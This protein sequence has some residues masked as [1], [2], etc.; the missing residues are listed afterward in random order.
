MDKQL[1]VCPVRH[2]A[3]INANAPAIQTDEL[4]LTYQA[5]DSTL[6]LL[7]RQLLNLHLQTGDR[8]ICLSENSLKL[9][10]LQL[11]CIRLGI[12]FC[13]LNPR[14]SA[15]EIKQRLSILKSNFIWLADPKKHSHL[16]SLSIDFSIIQDQAVT[17]V[18][19]KIDAQ[20]VC[21]II[22]T[23][24]SSG[25]AKAVMHSYSNH[26][27]SAL[28][29]QSRILLQAKD[30]NLLSLPLFHISGFAA[31]IR[32]LIAGA[33]LIVSAKKLSVSLLKKQKI[34]HLSLVATQLYRLLTLSGFQAKDLSIKHLL[35][36][37]SVFSDRLL[38]QTEQRGFIYHLSYGL[39]EMSS[40]VATSTNSKKL[41][42]LPGLQVKIINNEICLRG[43]MRFAGY[44]NGHLQSSVLPDQQWFASKDLGALMGNELSV[45]GRKDR[46]I[47]SGGENIQAEELESVL[48]SFSDIQQVYIVAVTDPLF[49]QRPVAFIDWVNGVI[50]QQQLQIYLQDK[51]SSYKRPAHYFVLPEQTGFKVSLKA[52]QTT[53]QAAHDKTL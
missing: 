11:T 29:S 38:A 2:Q 4:V 14:F 27:H 8:L 21:N 3:I 25:Q 16:S 31:V 47:I 1:N 9:I 53:A 50:K 6:N 39:S 36:G 46:L 12:I 22:F 34:T 10:L 35:L 33:T 32:T 49:G 26:Y 20:K 5:L 13:P 43:K 24:A 52:L 48:L 7:G 19:L 30:R 15:A 41:Q 40:Q 44:F 37:G 42:L 45:S 17:P 28:G 23:S 51:L 18:P